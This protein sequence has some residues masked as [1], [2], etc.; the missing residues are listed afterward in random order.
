MSDFF[1]IL[2]MIILFIIII[3]AV[4]LF[5]FKIFIIYETNFGINEKQ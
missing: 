5:H 4:V 1:G 2:L 3:V